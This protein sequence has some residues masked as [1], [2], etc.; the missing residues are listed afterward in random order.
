VDFPG[1]IQR[2][3]IIALIV[4]ALLLIGRRRPGTQTR[5]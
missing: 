4:A 2:A 1:E 5:W 3:V